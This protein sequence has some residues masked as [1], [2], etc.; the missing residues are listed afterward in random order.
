MKNNIDFYPHHAVSDQHAK[1]KML[2]VEFGWAG[3]GKFW[4]LNNRI[5]QSEE[6]CLNVSKKYNKAALA[7]D[8]DFTMVEFDNFIT[9]LKDDC[10]LIRECAEGTITTDIIQE[11]FGR[12]MQDRTE[13]RAR[14]RR[15]SGEKVK[16]SGEATYKGKESKGKEKKEKIKKEIYTQ[17]IKEK[18]INPKRESLKKSLLS[19]IEKLSALMDEFFIV[20]RQRN[21]V[22]K[23]WRESDFKSQFGQVLKLYNDL[24]SKELTKAECQPNIKFFIQE[25]IDAGWKGFSSTVKGVRAKHQKNL[26]LI[27]RFNN[28]KTIEL[29]SRPEIPEFDQLDQFKG[30]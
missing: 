15:A 7:S 8:L 23:D 9:F 2:R 1:F 22:K 30:K 11:T 3:E 25:A 27:D 5:A 18:L 29:D 26:D 21:D 28:K 4:A 10:E 19:N 17:V 13:A 14:H 6:C 20:R 16:A 24:S 12:V